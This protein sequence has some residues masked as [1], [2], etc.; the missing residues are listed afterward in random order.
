LRK[1]SKNGNV[2]STRLEALR[3]VKKRWGSNLTELSELMS[4]EMGKSISQSEAEVKKC[5][6]LLDYVIENSEELL[7]PE[8]IKTEARKSYVRFDPVGVVLLV[9]PW[10]FPAWQVMRAAI[11]A[12]A[13]GNAVILKHVS[14]VS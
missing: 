2:I 11:P 13:A 10:N 6:L 9:M 12:L 4:S 5:A 8:Y 7:A 14:I 1:L 3:E